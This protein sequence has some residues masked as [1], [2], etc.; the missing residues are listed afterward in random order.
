MSSRVIFH[1]SARVWDT[2]NCV[3]SW[4]SHA[5]RNAWLNGPVPPLALDAIGVRLMHST[6]QAIARSYE[7]AITAWATK[8][9]ACCDE[10]HWR[11]TVVPGT[12]HGSPA[13]THELRATL[14][15]C[16]P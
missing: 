11:S 9:T 14:V 6:P 4:P 16:S 7:P 8:W 12:C 3:L 2:S 5:S 1:F 10:P 13:A 15:L